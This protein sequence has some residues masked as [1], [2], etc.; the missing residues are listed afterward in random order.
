MEIMEKFGVPRNV[1]SFVMP[2]GYTFNL[3]GS[4]LYLALAVLFSTQIAGIN[5]NFEQQL[6]V[7]LALIVASKGIA[8]VPRVSLIVLAGTLSTFGYP[9]IG[10][11]IILGIDHILDMGRTTVNLIG[12][13]V[14]TAVVARWEHQFDDAKMHEFIRKEKRRKELLLRFSNRGVKNGI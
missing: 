10:V 14:A 5:L 11:A 8:A 7:M 13:C 4:T 6:M 1:V 12:N 2:T 9:L 3:D